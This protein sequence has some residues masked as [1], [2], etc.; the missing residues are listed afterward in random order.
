[1]LPNKEIYGDVKMKIFIALLFPLLLTF[2]TGCATSGSQAAEDLSTRKILATT[3]V[4][5]IS[6]LVTHIGGERVEVTGLMGAGVDPH[7]YK[8]SEG[9]VR[10][11]ER[12]D[13]IFYNGLHLEAGMS[14]VLERMADNRKVVEV[15]RGIPRDLLLAPAEFAGAYDPHVWFDVT[16]WMQAGETVRDSLIEIDPGSRDIYEQNYDKY[17]AE[18]EKLN[19]YVLEQVARIPVAHRV[20][21]TAHDA[22]NYF[23]RAYEFEVVGLQGISTEAEAST[24]DVQNLAEFIVSRQIP[25]IFVETS[26]SPRTIEAVQAAVK[27]RGW[28]V[29]IGGQLFSDAMGDANTVEGTYIGMVRY[30]VDTIVEALISQP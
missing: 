11:L 2:L 24:A 5:M 19:A 12:A 3:T 17:M 30:N 23:G 15:T 14:G 21:V 13:I 28:D 20:L 7:L 29:K 18:L 10:A 1:M 25:A 22:Y 8:A 27:S 9:D 16:L 6:D 4:G 26:I